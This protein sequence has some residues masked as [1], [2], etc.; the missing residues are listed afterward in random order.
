MQ[1]T[2]IYQLDLL[3]KTKTYHLIEKCHMI[4]H[5]ILQKVS[6]EEL[7]TPRVKSISYSVQTVASLVQR[8]LIHRIV[9]FERLHNRIYIVSLEW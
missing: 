9:A 4:K 1:S 3:T 7:S 2:L 5:L 8:L 6:I